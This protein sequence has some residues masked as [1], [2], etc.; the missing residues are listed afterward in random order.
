MESGNG[1]PKARD[2]ACA[3]WGRGGWFERGRPHLVLRAQVMAAIRAFFAARDFVEVDT[4]AVQHSPGLEPHLNAFAT[5]LALAGEGERPMFLHPS[6]EFAMK[7]LLAA[8]MERIFQLA[9]VFRNGDRGA[10]HH[11]EFMMLEWYRAGA[12]Y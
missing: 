9:H 6:P 3:G 8:G 4:P 12:S 10:L 11:P 5:R 7:K 2:S 1:R